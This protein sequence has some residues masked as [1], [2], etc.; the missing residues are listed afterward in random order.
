MG[1]LEDDFVFPSLTQGKAPS[2]R[3]TPPRGFS[4]G[5]GMNRVTQGIWIWSRPF[6]L[7]DQDGNDVVVILMDSEGL[8]SSREDGNWDKCVD[9]KILAISALISSVLVCCIIFAN[10][11]ITV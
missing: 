10:I 5:S 7:V 9:A 1:W 4:R 3:M 6:L 8:N 11:D 2:D